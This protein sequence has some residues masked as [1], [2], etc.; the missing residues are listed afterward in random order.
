MKVNLSYARTGILRFAA[1]ALLIAVC[2]P[3]AA[4]EPKKVPRIGIVG[5]SQDINDPKS[6]SS[7]L[8]QG[9]RELGYMEG[10]NILVELRNAEGKTER[11][12]SLVAELLQLNVDVL[13]STSSVAVRAAKQAS[14]TTPIVMVL[15]QDPV[16][17]GIVDSLA[18]PGGNVTG[19]TLLTRDLSGKRLEL[20]KELVPTISRVGILLDS[21]SPTAASE[22]KGYEAAVAALKVQLQSLEVRGPNPD[23]PAAFAAAAKGR[24]SALIAVRTSLINLN[25]KRI[26]DLA[27]KNRLPSMFERSEYVETGGLVSYAANDAESFKRAAVYV[28]KILKGVKPAELPVEQPTKF[29]LVINLNTA[30]QIGLTIPQSVLYR[31]D[32]VIK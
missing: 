18:R 4:Q 15:N 1:C 8:R 17:T 2:V 14:K 3:A 32:K 11:F 7:I 26:A 19:L 25:S 10:K 28:D 22:L 9:L 23:F 20:L 21:D 13:V 6:N 31:A 30:K 29:E 12:P 27:I 16:A 24:M 5:G